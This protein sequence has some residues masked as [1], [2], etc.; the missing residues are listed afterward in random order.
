LGFADGADGFLR[1][2]HFL[3]HEAM[4]HLSFF[5]LLKKVVKA[6]FN[7]LGPQIKDHLLDQIVKE[8]HLPQFNDDFLEPELRV[9]PKMAQITQVR[10]ENIYHLLLS[11]RPNQMEWRHYSSER[12]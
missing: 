10:P 6:L 4:L 8:S 1:D 9:S 12:I 7:D 5:S 11:L 2:I 3:D